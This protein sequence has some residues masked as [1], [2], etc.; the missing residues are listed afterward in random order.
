MKIS[1]ILTY[2]FQKTNLIL[3][4][5]FIIISLPGYAQ[6]PQTISLGEIPQKQLR[7]YIEARDINY[8]QNFTSI[9][10]SW[11]KGTDKST[12]HIHEKLFFLNYKLDDVWKCYRNAKPVVTWN[13]HFIRIGLLISKASN[14][15]TYLNNI[16]S[17]IVDTGQ[18]VFLDLRLWRGIFNVPLAFEI[19]NIDPHLKILEF[20]YIDSNTSKG[21]QTVQFF[22]NGDGRTRIIHSSYFKS[23]SHFR[24][25]FL[26]PHFHSKF[27]RQFHRNMKHELQHM[28][29]VNNSSRIS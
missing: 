20:S 2:V 4:I 25:K 26:Y 29:P 3:S 15:V 12:F 14:S 24:D 11:N 13:T 28:P 21:K 5:L 8:M 19:T 1:K 10:A 23:D 9:Q 27:I 22:D 18:V 17:P 16:N 7:K 6:R